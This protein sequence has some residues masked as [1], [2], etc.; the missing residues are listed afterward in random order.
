MFHQNL[1]PKQPLPQGVELR[2]LARHED[3]RGDLVEVFRRSWGG[4]V[5][6]V[7]WNLVRSR[8]GSLRGVHAHW[9][10]ADVLIPA[11]GP[12]WL[13][14]KDIRPGSAGFGAVCELDL[15]GDDAC[16]VTI[17]PGVA[18]GFYFQQE[19]AFL[20]GV[21]DYWDA[22]DELGCAWDDPALG[23][24]WPIKGDPHLSERDRN[25]GGFAGM[26]RAWSERMLAAAAG[27]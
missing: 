4:D 14:M 26:A 11:I 20:Y 24:S 15:H 27:G 19:A 2:P 10:H 12:F 23:F 17:P 9:R 22:G 21:T 1:R 8:P 3:A 25:A 18:H 7:Q 16:A 13:A 6:P 5:D